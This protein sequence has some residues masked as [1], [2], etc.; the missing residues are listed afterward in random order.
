MEDYIWLINRANRFEIAWTVFASVI[1][2]VLLFF[3]LTTTNLYYISTGKVAK[4]D[5]LWLSPTFS[6]IE[7]DESQHALASL[8][9][10]FAA[11]PKPDNI[12]P[13][14]PP[15]GAVEQPA[16]HQ[17]EEGHLNLLAAPLEEIDQP[18]P[19][20]MPSTTTA[21][22]VRVSRAKAEP[23]KAENASKPSTAAKSGTP[24]T[25]QEVQS[26]LQLLSSDHSAAAM[27]AEHSPVD[28]TAAQ[29]QPPPAEAAREKA[30]GEQR[31]AEATGEKAEQERLA[32]DDAVPEKPAPPIHRDKIGSY[33]AGPAAKKEAS[34]QAVKIAQVT[35]GQDQP[36]KKEA[37]LEGM[38]IPSIHGDL[39]MVIAGDTGIRLLV[40]FRDYPKSRR[41]RVPTR[42]EARREQRLV[43]VLAKTGQDITEAVIETA[44]E[45]IYVFSAESGQE[46]KATFTFKIF[47]RS[48]REKTVAIGARTVLGRTVLLKILMPEGIVWTDDTAFTGS[49]E[50][51]NSTTKFNAQT[52]LYWKEYKD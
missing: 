1:V 46:E 40:G 16:Q 34:G 32:K 48:T 29:G 41:N 2:H 25:P 33:R 3:L 28:L 47:E 43:P 51:S 35:T 5:V 23:V 21:M 15:A 50:D 49:L 4:F 39:K 26:D 12:Q 27:P 22:P 14:V 24:K 37:G 36:A 6:P 44:Q 11:D 8:P 18:S 10:E 7:A 13:P 31:A 45:G 20:V 42:S 19:P 17:S 38:V 52:G 9:W 30:A